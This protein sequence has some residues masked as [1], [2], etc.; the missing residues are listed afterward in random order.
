MEDGKLIADFV[1]SLNNE[2]PVLYVPGTGGIIRTMKE[3]FGDHGIAWAVRYD[4]DGNEIDRF[5]LKHVS[6]ITWVK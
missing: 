3:D 6:I 1:L 5:N 4:A 2:D